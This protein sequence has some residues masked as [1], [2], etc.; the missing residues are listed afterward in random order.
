MST[1][2]VGA[3]NSNVIC[4]IVIYDVE[5]MEATPYQPRNPTGTLE[6]IAVAFVLGALYLPIR[7]YNC[8]PTKFLK[9]N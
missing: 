5:V 6:E 4:Y 9:N 1:Y 3:L 8:R 7:C 2:S